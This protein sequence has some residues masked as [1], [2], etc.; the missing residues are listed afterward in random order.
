[1]LMYGQTSSGKT[2]TLFGDPDGDEDSRPDPRRS[3]GDGRFDGVLPGNKNEIVC[4]LKQDVVKLKYRDNMDECILS[5]EHQLRTRGKNEQ[6]RS[7]QLSEEGDERGGIIPRFLNS[8]F[9]EMGKLETQ[10]DARFTFEY[11]FFE[12][13]KEKIYD[14]LHQTYDYIDDGN[15]RFRRVLRALNLRETK[16]NQIMVGRCLESAGAIVTRRKPL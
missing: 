14:L 3:I 4:N 1:M 16:N 15:G 6:A 12:I 2:F 13:Y 8:L 9:D 11:S 10:E 5:S 7:S